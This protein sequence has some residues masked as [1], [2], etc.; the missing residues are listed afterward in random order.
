MSEKKKGAYR[1][2]VL[3]HEIK[4]YFQDL[5]ADGKIMLYESSRFWMG[6]LAGLIW[7]D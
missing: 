2:S 4:N 3:K 7:L 1:V 6:K 5:D